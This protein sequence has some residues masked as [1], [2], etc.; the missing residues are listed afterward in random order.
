LRFFANV[1]QAA[2]VEPVRSYW[3]RS[4][5]ISS[6]QHLALEKVY[7]NVSQPRPAN[8][9]GRCVRQMPACLWKDKT[10]QE[11]S[12]LSEDFIQAARQ[13]ARIL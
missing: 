12:N 11:Y 4:S 5:F 10:G 7:S 3:K 9:V 1:I 6:L 8:G 2:E 13:A